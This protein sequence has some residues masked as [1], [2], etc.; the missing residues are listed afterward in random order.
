MQDRRKTLIIIVAVAVVALGV[1]VGLSQLIMSP[2]DA[3]AERAA[4]E[5]G[6]ITVPVELRALES[7]IVT[8]GDAAFAGA[9]DV[10]LEVGGLGAPP[11]VT[12][13]VP[14]RG[15]ELAE[16]DVVLEVTGRPVI[17]LQGE[18]P[19]YRALRPGMTGPDVE[20][21]EQ[22][23]E[24]LGHDPGTVD[25]S[26]TAATASAV[27]DL[28]DEVGYEAPAPDPQAEA[29]LAAAQDAAN[30]ADDAVDQAEDALDA[31]AEGPSTAEVLQAEQ[32]VA[33][34]EFAL[35]Q[36]QDSGTDQEIAQAETQLELAE[37]NLKDLKAGPDTSEQKDG[38]DDARARLS[39]AITARDEAAV[40]AGTLL[41]ITEVVYIAT[42]PR[43][44]DV[45]NVQVGATVEGAVMSVSGADMVITAM[46]SVAERDL[47]SEEMVAQIDLPTGEAVEATI[48]EIGEVA[49]EGEGQG[50]VPIRITPHDLTAEQT[51]MLRAT[52][53]RVEI[54]V[55]S[56]EGE[57]LAVPLAALTAGPG[58]ES[59]VEVDREGESVLV[60]V[61]V[62]LTADGFAEVSPVD[63]QM[64]EGDLVVVGQ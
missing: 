32:A 57:V 14:E 54:P 61:E 28:Y 40:A 26:Y 62:G 64:A 24:R 55:S 60:E 20:Q 50:S 49:Q 1:G 15:D 25:D 13:R 2:A 44:V 33:D 9:V 59:R 22:T 21:L 18:L 4:P 42:L 19:M 41:P 27:E 35:E 30:A 63:G 52:N 36:A 39:D 23:L 7:R 47:L 51:E 38:L 6:A 53:V 56:T 16:G 5:A 46:V 11:I 45:V 3:A 12:G 58:G 17:A 10:T 43:R 31:A 48:A 34:A 37:L 29:E 8:R